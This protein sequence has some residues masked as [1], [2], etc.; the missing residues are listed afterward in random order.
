[1]TEREYV[2]G[3]TYAGPSI[4]ETLG[5]ESAAAGLDREVIDRLKHNV[6]WRS[7]GFLGV[8]EAQSQVSTFVLVALSA[9]L[10]VWLAFVP[11]L[12]WSLAATFVYYHA[13]E[14]GVPDLLETAQPA[15]ARQRHRP[16]SLARSLGVSAVKVWLAGAQSVV[17]ARTCCR[18]LGKP[19]AGWRRL[20]RFGVLGVGLTM[21]G[22]STSQHVLRRAGYRGADL[23]RLGFVGS[24]LNVPYRVLLSALFIDLVRRLATVA[25]G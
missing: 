23:L 12:V 19:T 10:P 21:F 4:E 22:V 15:A 17:Y 5:F 9:L 6:P 11:M 7:V 2:S 20:A 18:V 1:M 14:R 24:C 8:W 3:L 13:R 25:V 16:L